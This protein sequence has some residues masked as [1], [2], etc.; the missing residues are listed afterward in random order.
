MWYYTFPTIRHQLLSGNLKW[1]TCQYI[2]MGGKCNFLYSQTNWFE[3]YQGSWV[4]S[5]LCSWKATQLAQHKG[6]PVVMGTS[7]MLLEE[8][9]TPKNLRYIQRIM[10]SYY[11]LHIDFPSPYFW[12][13]YF[14]LAIVTSMLYTH[15]RVQLQKMAYHFVLQ[16]SVTRYISITSIKRHIFWNK[17]NTTAVSTVLTWKVLKLP[18]VKMLLFLIRAHWKYQTYYFRGKLFWGHGYHQSGDMGASCSSLS[19]STSG[20]CTHIPSAFLIQPFLWTRK[21]KKLW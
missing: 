1:H 12:N 14:F 16:F 6:L 18:Y 2:H 11:F 15:I 17:F 20:S 13:N 7:V 5:G 8:N 10:C 19:N 21:S 9:K 3:H 4:V